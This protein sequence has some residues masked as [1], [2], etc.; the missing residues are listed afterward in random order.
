METEKNINNVGETMT[1]DNASILL[2]RIREHSIKL[3]PEMKDGIVSEIQ[4]G[5]DQALIGFLIRNFLNTYKNGGDV[6][7][8]YLDEHQMYSIKQAPNDAEALFRDT[9][10]KEN[11]TEG[12]ILAMEELK[13]SGI[14]QYVAFFSQSLDENIQYIKKSFGLKENK[15][16]IIIS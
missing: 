6:L 15:S 4:M 12:E 11:L 1:T 9:Y 13:R 16:G 2:K 14:Q 8:K 5:I 3:S 7:N 10:S